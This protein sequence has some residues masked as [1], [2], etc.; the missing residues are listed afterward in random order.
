MAD[1]SIFRLADLKRRLSKLDAQSA[2][3]GQERRRVAA[4]VAALEALNGRPSGARVSKAPASP[5]RTH[6][7]PMEVAEAAAAVLREVGN[8]ALNAT[9][10]TDAINKQNLL[11][12]E[13]KRTS[14]VSA[15]DAKYHAGVMFGKPAPGMYVLLDAK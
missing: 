7:K 3:I 6:Q 5:K 11:G 10:I 2:A 9:T 8:K 1:N 14:V 12:R 13:I 4:A 15:M